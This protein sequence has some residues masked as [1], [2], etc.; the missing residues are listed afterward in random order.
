MLTRQHTKHGI[1]FVQ[2]QLLNSMTNEPRNFPAASLSFVWL[3]VQRKLI[4]LSRP[5]V[6]LENMKPP[7]SCSWQ[8]K[9]KQITWVRP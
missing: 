7:S 8:Q 6:S 1:Q 9:E 4:H 3:C 5:N 2:L